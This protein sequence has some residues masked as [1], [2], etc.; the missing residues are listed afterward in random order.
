MWISPR[1]RHTTLVDRVRAFVERISRIPDARQGP[2]GPI[3]AVLR[4]DFP[5]AL[6]FGFSPVIT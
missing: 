6:R 3:F 5:L 4:H 1:R 2:A